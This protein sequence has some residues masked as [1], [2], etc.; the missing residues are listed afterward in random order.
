MLTTDTGS[1]VHYGACSRRA[2]HT[3][4]LV[5]QD[6]NRERDLPV[7]PLTLSPDSASW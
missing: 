5:V 4:A 3:L 1:T 2:T 7:A 6:V